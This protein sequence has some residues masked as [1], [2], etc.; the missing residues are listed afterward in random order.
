M[1]LLLVVIFLLE[2]EKASC[3]PEKEFVDKFKEFLG[4]RTIGKFFKELKNDKEKR[5]KYHFS[6]NKVDLDVFYQPFTTNK[7]YIEGFL[8]EERVMRQMD[9]KKVHGIVKF[10]GCAQ[11]KNENNENQFL[12]LYERL[13]YNLEKDMKKISEMDVTGR[14]LFYVE[15]LENYNYF[16]EQGYLHNSVTFKD[17]HFKKNKKGNFYPVIT[18][19]KNAHLKGDENI[20]QNK[21][22]LY[23]WPQFGNSPSGS[24]ERFIQAAQGEMLN[25]YVLILLSEYFSVMPKE[26]KQD[27]RQLQKNIYEGKVDLKKFTYEMM[28]DVER[29]RPSSLA[30][31]EIEKV[32]MLL[33]QVYTSLTNKDLTP[34]KHLVE[35]FKALLE[36]P[37]LYHVDSQEY[38]EK[39]KNQSSPNHSKTSSSSSSKTSSTSSSHK[40]LEGKGAPNKSASSSTS[41][42]QKKGSTHSSQKSPKSPSKS[43]NSLSKQSSAFLS[44]NYESKTGESHD[45]RETYMNTNMENA[46]LNIQQQN[47]IATLLNPLRTSSNIPEEIFLTAENGTKLS[48]PDGKSSSKNSLLSDKISKKSN[49]SV[50]SQNKEASKHSDSSSTS[51]YSSKSNS[52][53]NTSSSSPVSSDFSSKIYNSEIIDLDQNTYGSQHTS[54]NSSAKKAASKSSSHKKSQERNDD[55]QSIYSQNTYSNLN[56]LKLGSRKSNTSPNPLNELQ[57]WEELNG[58]KSDSPKKSHQSGKSSFKSRNSDHGSN[59]SQKNKSQAL[60]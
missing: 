51:T 2:Q 38:Q 24:A 59:S 5:T 58:I 47:S 35:E 29:A 11:D 55:D 14:L 28:L 23:K 36:S 39:L 50:K 52:K 37:N 3:I 48:S 40:S 33:Q 41:S 34:L 25:V 27:L 17:V 12:F 20:V 13:E 21:M 4:I 10:Y 43:E 57:G 31:K 53:Q 8:N 1:K 26:L 46:E 30:M 9:Q 45:L 42:S 16:H 54:R 56:S 60:L 32:Q 6:E 44:K 15:L 22:Q 49:H 19:F 7:N 18:R